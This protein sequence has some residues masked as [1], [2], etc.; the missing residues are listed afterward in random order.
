[1]PDTHVLVLTTYTDD[2]LFPALQAGARERCSRY[3]TQHDRRTATPPEALT[4]RETEILKLIADGLSK[5]RDPPQARPHRRD[6]QDA[7]QP[8]PESSRRTRTSLAPASKPTRIDAVAS[9]SMHDTRSPAPRVGDL[10]LARSREPPGAASAP[11]WSRHRAVPLAA[12]PRATPRQLETTV[13]TGSGYYDW[14]LPFTLE[15]G[16]GGNSF[17][18]RR[19]RSC[20]NCWPLVS[21]PK[22]SA[23]KS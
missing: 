1:V 9:S 16:L 22:R 19:W 2:S 18:A 6:R 14:K 12:A 5:R 17:V 23:P 15:T 10:L 4:P 21:R 13:R 11:G 20:R 8:N 3:T 7:H